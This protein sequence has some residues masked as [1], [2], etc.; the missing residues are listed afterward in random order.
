[1]N[2]GYIEV[3]ADAE[4]KKDVFVGVEDVEGGLQGVEGPS[5]VGLQLSV[6]DEVDQSLYDFEEQKAAELRKKSKADKA[7]K[8][9]LKKA[10]HVEQDTR[11]PIQD[12]VF[13]SRTVTGTRPTATKNLAQRNGRVPAPVHFPSPDWQETEPRHRRDSHSHIA[14]DNDYDN[15][16]RRRGREYSAEPRHT[17]RGRSREPEYRDTRPPIRNINGGLFPEHVSLH[18]PAEQAQ[19][20]SRSLSHTPHRRARSISASPDR[21][22]PSRSD[23]PEVGEKRHR[24]RSQDPDDVRP[25][26]VPKVA[27][28]SRPRARDL[29]DIDREYTMHSIERFRCYLTSIHLFP[30]HIQEAEFAK[31]TWDDTCKA[32]GERRTFTPTIA[33]L[34]T[35][36]GPHMRGE[37][38]TKIKPLTEVVYGFKSGNSRKTITFNRD[39]AEKLKDGARFAFKDVEQ[40]KGLFKAPLIQK[41]ANVMYYKNRRD[42]GVAHPDCFNPFRRQGVAAIITTIENTIDE[43]ATGIKTDIPFTANEY[44]SV[45]E[46]HLKSLDR[47]AEHTAKYEL[48]D[49]IL[50][51]IHNGGRFHAGVQPVSAP[52]TS[53][54]TRAVLDAALKEYEDDS[55]TETE[56]EDGNSDA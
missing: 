16:N 56:G 27:T 54:L 19:R 25:A 48:L 20:R 44:R 15:D 38:K 50:I 34:I 24:S 42:E 30:D 46:G 14:A 23:S 12:D 49:K 28:G 29:D 10:G 33:K 2:F 35:A 13:T 21:G 45:Y 6:V 39:L 9:A 53:A 52:S 47:F 3:L 4:L 43:Y 11:G 37:L 18:L 31:M 8:A 32:Y 22:R 51:R 40:K 26:Q 1:M 41:A 5:G 36:W 55:E 7:A 17:F